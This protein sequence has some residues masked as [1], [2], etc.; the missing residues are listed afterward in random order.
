MI[1]G[2]SWS[3]RLVASVMSVAM[4]LALVPVGVL[5]TQAYA[6]GDD[7]PTG[8]SAEHDLI[9]KAEEDGTCASGEALV[10][11]HASGASKGST[12]LIS[13]QSESDPLAD[14]GF[15]VAETVDLSAVDQAEA[16]GS[17]SAQSDD[18]SGL[19]SGSDVRVAL[20]RRDGT[21]VADLVSSLEAL[22]CVECAAPNYD[23]QLCSV[24]ETPNDFFYTKGMQYGLS[25]PT[26]GVG[27]QAALRADVAAGS[28][29]K[30]NIVAVI[31]TGVDYT[32]PDLKNNMW[33]DPGDIG[34][35]PKG[36]YGYDAYY[37]D[38][39][40]MPGTDGDSSHGTHCA[41]LVAAQTNNGEGVAG[42]AQHTRI[43]GIKYGDDSGSNNNDLSCA[44]A[45]QFVITAKLAGQNVVAISNSWSVGT[46]SP[47]LDYL[48]NQAGKAGM[49]SFFAASN[50]NA[51]TNVI[52]GSAVISITSPYAVVVAATDSANR[53]ASF[54]DYNATEVDVAA[55][56]ASML[57]TVPVGT[58]SRAS[59]APYDPFLARLLGNKAEYSKPLGDLLTSTS[60]PASGVKIGLIYGGGIASAADQAHL[61]YE[62]ADVDG[63]SSIRF[64][65]GDIEGLEHGAAG[66]ASYAIAIAWSDANPFL[67]AT[68]DASSC[69][70]SSNLM[71]ASDDTP[72]GGGG[73]LQVSGG[74][75]QT[76]PA[77]FGIAEA[78]RD[79][80][81]SSVDTTA[82]SL[83]YTLMVGGLSG[84]SSGDASLYATC[85]GIAQ[86]SDGSDYAYMG[87]TSMSTPFLAGC[88]AELA[89][90]YPDDSAL[91]L[92]GR[93]VGGTD[94]VSG[95]SLDKAGN[96][97]TTAT[98][99]RFTF[100]RGADS[101]GSASGS[102]ISANTWSISC[103][104]DQV[105]LHGY[106]LGDASLTVDGTAVT[107][108]SKA[109][110]SIVFA[111]SSALLDG[112]SH[113][114]DVTDAS[115]GRTHKASYV[116]PKQTTKQVVEVGALPSEATSG[117]GQLVSA[118]D[119][120]FFA[121]G[122]GTYL[123]CCK[124]PSSA[125]TVSSWTKLAAPDKLA[126]SK[127]DSEDMT[128]IRYVYRDGKL[129]ALCADWQSST[130]TVAAFRCSTYDITAGTWSDVQTLGTFD[131]K[132]RSNSSGSVYDFLTSA[133]AS[134]G[135]VVFSATLEAGDTGVSTASA[136]MLFLLEPGSDT[137][138]QVTV[139][140]GT[141]TGSMGN[142]QGFAGF[143]RSG[144][145]L[146][147]L[148]ANADHDAA[149]GTLDALAYDGSSW[150]NLGSSAGEYPMTRIQALD[151]M[152]TA[153]SVVGNGIVEVGHLVFSGSTGDSS[154]L[155]PT[156]PA[157][158][159]LGS[160]LG[161]SPIVISSA[162]MLADQVYL[163][164]VDE[165]ALYAIPSATEV[166]LT[167]IDSTLTA[168]AETGGSASVADWRGDASSALSARRGDALVWTATASNGYAFDG[169]YAADGSL[170]SSDPSFS[171]TCTGDQTLVAL[172]KAV[173]AAPAASTTASLSTAG[174]ATPSTGDGAPVP[175]A[176]MA[177]AGVA[178]AA[179]GL[180]RRR[181]G[182]RPPDIPFE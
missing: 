68:T 83:S 138:R 96:V 111:A 164:G 73:N 106:G 91:E 25:S 179:W 69:V 57:S 120:L 89:S 6:S 150:K 9:V 3:A 23:H 70:F 14:A 124:D 4:A 170:V 34:L 110:D 176:M 153:K 145:T 116:V 61:H 154:L 42:V 7:A 32:N 139:P 107:P 63:V 16:S 144:S 108:S 40:C 135:E 33:T 140:R 131:A 90:L 127:I 146:Y 109:A 77:M 22:D 54:S 173:V 98:D 29:A 48:I 152:Q 1:N 10:V 37:G 181:A 18:G 26:A 51:N 60:T 114:F 78:G 46:Y 112:G 5:P 157:T 103:D 52:E 44:R 86:K 163:S 28:A 136:C 159:S 71:Q 160:L 126:A 121:D 155:D 172:F 161:S 13:M 123:Y 80:T 27:Y 53:Y 141:D 12:G 166:K 94:P 84:V 171:T 99:G 36:S 128:T 137:F 130:S 39:D 147:C 65:I 64:T 149:S 102:S 38:Y 178:L 62:R 58:S 11:Y 79:G 122:D 119:R 88:Y 118:T 134:E 169:W 117:L 180:G 75:T 72:L 35:G 100:E 162:A 87:G 56:G 8:P 85:A 167:S 113:R 125:T 81:F 174:S 45:Y 66:L 55:P 165:P 74:S 158:T 129:Y 182:L 133:F 49:M 104:G 115:T 30:D 41:G 177:L 76:T 168:V 2:R 175:L 148:A 31:D 93:I 43:M 17:L 19:A 151:R 59:Q 24:T 82:A 97:K 101:A 156:T 132:G 143:Y 95:T 142:I 15:D 92:R 47:V 67:G 21:S 20:V 105:T 50:D